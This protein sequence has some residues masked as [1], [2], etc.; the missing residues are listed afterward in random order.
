MHTGM[1]PHNCLDHMVMSQGIHT[2]SDVCQL[3][4]DIKERG[5]IMEIV[6]KGRRDTLECLDVP[7]HVL[8]NDPV[9]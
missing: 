2:Q 6:P 1:C 7:N 5:M 8:N 4:T 9:A 3:S